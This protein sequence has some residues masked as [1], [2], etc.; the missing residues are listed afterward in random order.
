MEL[1]R[2]NLLLTATVAGSLTEGAFGGTMPQVQ[3]GK[4]KVSRLIVGGNPISG[5]SHV[6]PQLDR[7]MADYFTTARVKK[8]LKHCE[9]AGIN[10]WQSRG[11]RHITRLLQEY[12]LEGGRIQWIAQTASE[13]ADISRNI[14]SLAALNPIGI[15]HHGTQTDRFWRTGKM[16]PVQE[17][18]KVIRQTGVMVGLGTHIPEVID[19]AES[20][21]WDLDFYMTCLYNL[22]RTAEEESKLAGKPIRGEFFHDPDRESMLDR[23]ARTTKP[24]LLFKIYGAG[25]HSD[26]PERKRAAWQL[27]AGRA[28]PSDCFVVGMYPK[29]TEQVKENCRL[30]REATHR[31]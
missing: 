25:R 8:L 29:H 16:E 30:V 10:T 4:W 5:N 21:G 22:S 1:P 3:W 20:K 23:V 13:L 19:Y 14:R 2:R 7:E 27:A 26:T 11:D 28:K 15:Y 6:S 18:L 24:C 17:M 31:S 9:D 12:R